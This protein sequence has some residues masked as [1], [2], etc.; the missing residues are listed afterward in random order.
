VLDVADMAIRYAH[1]LLFCL[2]RAT[3]VECVVRQHQNS[4]YKPS[5]IKELRSLYRFFARCRKEA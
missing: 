1:G 4:A 5:A 3:D 2:C